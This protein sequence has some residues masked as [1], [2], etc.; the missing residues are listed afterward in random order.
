MRTGRR[1]RLR[2]LGLR[3]LHHGCVLHRYP[4]PLVLAPL[5]VPLRS[6]GLHH[7]LRA[8]EVGSHGRLRPRQRRRG[9]PVAQRDP[10]LTL[11]V[12]RHEGLRAHALLHAQIRCRCA[13]HGQRLRSGAL[14]RLRRVQRI[15]ARVRRVDGRLRVCSRCRDASGGKRGVGRGGR[16]VDVDSQLGRLSPTRKAAVGLRDILRRGCRSRGVSDGRGGVEVVVG[17]KGG[18]GREGGIV[19]VTVDRQG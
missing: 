7:G 2:R 9:T 1:R 16:S 18:G 14:H 17:I 10:R 8:H 3:R 11:C 5:L 12:D 6:A 4:P 15:E 13:A 19:R